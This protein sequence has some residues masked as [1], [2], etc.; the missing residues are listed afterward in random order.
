M[1]LGGSAMM[2]RVSLTR[3]R[4]THDVLT[5]QARANTTPFPIITF[6]ERDIRYV[7]PWLDEPM[8]ISVIT[9]EYKI[10][11]V[12]IDQGNFAN[13][14]YWSTYRKLGLLLASLEEC[15]GTLYE[16]VGEQVP[17]KEVIELETTFGEGNHACSIPILYTVVDMDA[18]YNIIMGRP[19]LNKLGMVVSKLHLCMKYLVG[20]EI[21][22][23]WVDT[24][25]AQCCYEDSL[26]VGSQS[27]REMEPAINVLDLDLDPRCQSEHERPLPGEDLKEVQIGP[28]TTHKTKIG[29]T[30]EKEEESRLMLF[31]LENMDVFAWTPAD[32]PGIDPN[33]MKRKQGE[34]KRKAA[35][36]ETSKLLATRFI[37]E[38]QYP[39]WLAN[40]VMVKKANGKWRMCTNYTDLNK[41]CPKDPYLLPNIDRLMDKALG[42]A[43]LS[44]MDAYSRYNKIR[45][46]P[47][48]KAKTAFIINFEAFCYKVMPFGLKNVGVTYQRLMDKIFKEIIGIDMEVYIDDMVVK[49]TTAGEHCNTLERVKHQLKLNLKKCFFG[50]QAGNFLGFI[51]TKRGIETNP[52]KCQAVIN[53]R[54]SQSVREVQQLAGRIITLFRFISRE[55]DFLRTKAILAAPP[56][57]TRTTLGIPLLV[58]ISVSDDVVSSIIVQEKEGKQYLVYFTSKVLQ[59]SERRYQK[60]EKGSSRRHKHLEK[61]TPLFSRSSELTYPSDKCCESQTWP[62]GWWHGASSYLSS[63]SPLKKEVISKLRH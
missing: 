59:S 53:M 44:F 15:S 11:R 39:T 3:R 25:V 28:S 34:E 17:I 40:V 2:A 54:S 49:F 52:E 4:G 60:I 19:V 31:L 6:S 29:T 56:V 45:M 5:V 27:S 63:T 1:I 35:K 46:H 57:L 7:P 18:S 32:M 23:V 24:R 21:G 58:Y 8:V 9:T 61:T 55:E 48:D 20:K 16:F 37:K 33:F 30:L 14:L 43:L 62:E 47:Q 10:E 13:I 42:F 26:R 38:V 50:V 12:L 22:S 51:L 41:A 36:D